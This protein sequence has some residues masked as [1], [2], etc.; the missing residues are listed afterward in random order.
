M[1]TPEPFRPSVELVDVPKIKLTSAGFINVRFTSVD[2]TP[3]DDEADLIVDF[4]MPSRSLEAE[5]TFTMTLRDTPEPVKPDCGD[6]VISSDLRILDGSYT[7]D[8]DMEV[9]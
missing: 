8:P 2:F 1:P 4:D 5:L 3:V 6:L 9:S 7:S